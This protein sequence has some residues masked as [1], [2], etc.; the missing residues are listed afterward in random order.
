LLSYVLKDLVRNPRRT[1]T[2]VA[3]VALAVGLFSGIA[4]FVD[5]ASSQMTTR[6]IAPVSID[7]QAAVVAPLTSATAPAPDLAAIRRAVVS[8]SGVASTEPLALVDLPAGRVRSGSSVISQP[9]KVLAV[10]PAYLRA[11][12]V[13]RVS[14][15]AY[16]PGSALLSGPAA[17]LLSASPG[18]TVELSIPGA[19]APTRLPLSGIADFTGPGSAQLFASRN[20]DT[21]GEATAAPNVVVIDFATFTSQVLPALRADA[22]S[23]APVIAT[24]P[25]VEFHVALSRGLLSG[26]PAAALV[27]TQGLRRTIER[28]APGEIKVIDNLS[29][30]LL[31]AQR[32]ST[33]AKVLFLFLGLPGVLL[34]AYLSR[35]AGSLLA[36]AQRRERATLRARGMQPSQA[37]RGLAYNT[38]AV[39]LLGAAAGLVMGLAALGLLFGTSPNA[40]APSSFGLSIA[41]SILA[42]AA[43]T[44]LALYLPAR[45]AL[46][47]QVADERREVETDATP[48]W[49]RL[50]LDMVMLAAAAVVGGITYLTGGY[51]PTPIEGQS[52][53]LSFFIL[54]APLC[55]WVGATLLLTRLLL[56]VISRGG[57]ARS[58]ADLRRGLVL[59]TLALSVRRRPHAVV[60]GVVALSLAV[61]FGSSLA[62]F[63]N[64]Y[65]AQKLADAR[66]VVGGDIRVTPTATAPGAA[67]P[68]R[69]DAA[70]L[71]RVPGVRAVTPMSTGTVVV[72]TDRKA[73]AAIDPTG[74]PGVAGLNTSFFEGGLTPAEA[75]RLLRADPAAALIDSELAKAFNIQTGDTI[76]V[77][78]TDTVTGKPVP[79]T[80]HTIGVFRNFPGFPQGV[81]I[82]SNLAFFQA[83][84]H[85]TT[86]DTYLLSTRA[87]DSATAAV[88]RAVTAL[89]TPSAPIAVNTTAKAY[90]IDQSSLSSLN[91]S[92]L[93]R[94][95]GL[96]TILMSALG[97]AIFVFGLLLQRAREHVTLR[98]LG[99]RMSHMQG[100]VLGEAGLVS[101]VSLV[102]GGAVGTAMSL[103]FVQ[104]LRPLFTLP[105][106]GIAVPAGTL[107]LL[108]ILVLAAMALSSVV[109]GASLRRLRLVE[110]LREE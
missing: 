58:S 106:D 85:S 104:I 24:P 9:V 44:T 48:A 99:L 67:A 78:L 93:G 50:R 36:Q 27:R 51:K 71:A 21:Q 34:A 5:S 56:A 107:A 64:T 80:L 42:A 23:P 90:N 89:G 70:T 28:A 87:D 62:I 45:R 74:F 61:A 39:A 46:S 91:I 82:V 33:L 4:F 32:D 16:A 76:K 54:L 18:A 65:Q 77:Q 35:Y 30:A 37:M 41:A 31:A 88:A 38:M 52:I 17:E 73:F 15:G 92:G 108:A 11:F 22:A 79:V 63:V 53:S 2:S 6:A 68:R 72:G 100:L 20:P 13:L 29:D 66:F 95:E 105:P 84:T 81:D 103:M 69:V 40:V 10:D 55:F 14:G 1:L 59:K 86:P 109:A 3:G 7:M 57:S 12:P 96:Y 75:M 98:A 19:A 49:L 47:R 26:D 94:L 83:T 110:I 102:I 8:V 97:I 25:V 101:V 60:S 43:T